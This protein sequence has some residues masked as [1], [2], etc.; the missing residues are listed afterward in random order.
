MTDLIDKL[1]DAT[2]FGAH[3]DTSVLGSLDSDDI[4]TVRRD[5]KEWLWQ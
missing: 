4:S 5:R 2:V 1:V 3:K